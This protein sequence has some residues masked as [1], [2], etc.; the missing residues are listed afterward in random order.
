M[1]WQL[2]ND[3]GVKGAYAMRKPE[4]AAKLSEQLAEHGTKRTVGKRSLG[5]NVMDAAKKGGSKAAIPLAIGAYMAGAG[6]SEAADGS[7]GERAGNAAANFGTGAGAAYGGIKLS[8]LLS[9]AAPNVMRGLG[10]GA[11]MAMPGEVIGGMTDQFASPEA[12]NIAARYLPEALQFGAVNEARE[13]ATVP[14]RSPA[15]TGP[16]VPEAE[17]SSGGFSPNVQGRLQRMIAG[18]ADPQQIA[19]FL[20]QAA[21]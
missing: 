4:L 6:D 17:A 13:M 7:M 3:F 2:K 15:N 14:P 5:A 1:A 12:R 11:A 10:S 16:R 18:G 21:R 8:D 9:K 20:N 19:S